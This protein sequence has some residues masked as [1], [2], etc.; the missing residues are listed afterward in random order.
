[1]SKNQS[2]KIHIDKSNHF[3]A[4]SIFPEWNLWNP[5]VRRRSPGIP[6]GAIIRLLRNIFRSR[7]AEPFVIY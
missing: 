6:L 1:M 3:Q 7:R 5:G 4:I 2:L